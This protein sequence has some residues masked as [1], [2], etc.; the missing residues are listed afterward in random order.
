[1][2]FRRLAVALAALTCVGAAEAP[3][4][5]PP[6][7]DFLVAPPTDA[8]RVPRAYVRFAPDR[9][10]DILWEND[11]TAHR[12]YGPALE[13]YEPPAGSG[14][15]AWGKSV[16]HPFMDRQLKTGK[17]HDYHGE[18][19]DAYDVGTAR[20]AGGSWSRWAGTAS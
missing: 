14:I 13:A 7:A 3:Q 15:D 16:R 6:K 1:M 12:I 17:Q 4:P 2:S 19:L 18:G 8:Q 11:R 5:V 20:G 10:D 9:Y